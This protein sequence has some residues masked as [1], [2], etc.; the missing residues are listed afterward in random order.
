LYLRLRAAGKKPLGAMTAGMHKL[1]IHMNRRLK[2]V[3]SNLSMNT[4]ANGAET[5]PSRDAAPDIRGK[6]PS[7]C[8]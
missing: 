5:F 4:V 3:I 6:L 1:V 2:K 7:R 8:G